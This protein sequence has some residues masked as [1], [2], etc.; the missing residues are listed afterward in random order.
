[1]P[2]TV[3]VIVTALAPG[4]A[5]TSG[6]FYANGLLALAMLISLSEL[7]LASRTLVEDVRSSFESPPT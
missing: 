3:D 2:G 4:V 7:Y 1:M 5:L 6:I